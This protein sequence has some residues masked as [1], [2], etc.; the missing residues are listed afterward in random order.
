VSGLVFFNVF[1]L[2][3]DSLFMFYHFV[4]Q[5]RKGGVGFFAF[6]QKKIKDD[7]YLFRVQY[8]LL[9]LFAPFLSVVI[10]VE[11]NLFHDL[12]PYYTYMVV[13][14]T[15]KVLM[16]S[17]QVLFVYGITSYRLVKE[18]CNKKDSHEFSNSEFEKILTDPYLRNEFEKFCRKEMSVENFSCYEDILEFN[19]LETLEDKLG[20]AKQ[21]KV[22]YLMSTSPKEVN[23]GN[24]K[25]L[26]KSIDEGIIE[27][28]MFEHVLQI[29]KTNMVDSYCRFI[30]D[31]KYENLLEKQ[32]LL[33]SFVDVQSKFNSE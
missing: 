23:I 17:F 11:N 12:I 25:A 7:I 32:N 20:K 13:G 28:D 8:Y 4:Q 16:V 29:L 14:I 9:F 19:M 26:N 24:V 18:K 3:C 22:L 31:P 6:F 33:G 10:T 1:F 5:W 2:I 15:Y 27:D 21:I 30:I